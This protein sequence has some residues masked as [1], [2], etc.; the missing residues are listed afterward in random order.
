M[1]FSLKK[2]IFGG[3]TFCCCLPVRFGVLAM[4]LISILL[5]GVLLIGIWFKTSRSS[6][7]TLHTDHLRSHSYFLGGHDLT[8]KERSVL[9]LVGLVETLL[10]VASVLGYVIQR[11]PLHRPVLINTNGFQILWRSC[12]E[13]AVCHDLRL[14][15]LW[16][17]NHQRHC[18][19][20]LPVDGHP[21]YED[22]FCQG[23]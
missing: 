4:T 7:P 1:A 11:L 14:F 8:S 13:A 17:S 12:A 20:L 22:G 23:V 2:F 19:H 3:K 5:T 10:F 6:L 18:R 21:H 16:P 9:I 15:R